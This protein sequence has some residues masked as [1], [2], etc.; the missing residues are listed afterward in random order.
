LLLKDTDEMLRIFKP[1]IICDLIDGFGFVENP[2]F[3]FVDYFR[4]NVFLSRLGRF[5]FDQIAKIAS[6]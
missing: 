3:R 5:L 2:L 1:E 4:L 6:R